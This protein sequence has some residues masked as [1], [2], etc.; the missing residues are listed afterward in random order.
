MAPTPLVTPRAPGAAEPLTHTRGP[1]PTH[2]PRSSPTAL[3]AVTGRPFLAPGLP[4]PFPQER[5]ARPDPP[6]EA[7]TRPDPP[8]PQHR[9]Q[10]P[11]A[12]CARAVVSCNHRAPRDGGGRRGCTTRAGGA[13]FERRLFL[14]EG[15]AE[16]RLHGEGEACSAR[17][18]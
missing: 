6:G 16:H 14:P 5:P 2:K 7:P 1:A 12:L 8:V 13:L 17:S 3:P 9:P 4:C 10:P 15:S 11:G 18:M